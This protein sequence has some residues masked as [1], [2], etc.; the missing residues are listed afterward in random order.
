MTEAWFD[1]VRFGALY[2]AIGGGGL[3]VIGGVVGAMAGYFAPRGKARGFILGAFTC[4]LIVGV[5]HLVVGVYALVTGQPYGIWY[6]LLLTGVILSAVMG[7]LLP[8]VRMRYAQAESR[9]M[10]AA[11]LRRG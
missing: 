10:E 1:P 2:G 6:A 4:L 3:G 8:V 9:R 11:A 7:G 5:A